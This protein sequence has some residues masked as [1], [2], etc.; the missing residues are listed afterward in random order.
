MHSFPATNLNSLKKGY[1]LQTT[2]D[3]IIKKYDASNCIVEQQ[4]V[5]CPQ[6]AIRPDEAPSAEMVP[7][8]AVRGE[9]PTSETHISRMSKEYREVE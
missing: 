4:G 5:N 1:V 6:K 2:L 3:K 8:P 7:G 9:A